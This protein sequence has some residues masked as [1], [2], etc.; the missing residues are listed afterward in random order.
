VPSVRLSNSPGMGSLRRSQHPSAATHVVTAATC[1]SLCSPVTPALPVATVLMCQRVCV[2]GVGVLAQTAEDHISTRVRREM[3]RAG[4]ALVVRT[5][6]AT[7]I[8]L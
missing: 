2:C 5:P 1:Q 3:K 4:T 6:I 7:P 8:G